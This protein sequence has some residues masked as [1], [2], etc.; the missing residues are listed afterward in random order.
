MTAGESLRS[1][2][3][4]MTHSGFAIENA[5]VQAIDLFYKSIIDRR[6][7]CGFFTNKYNKRLTNI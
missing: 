2:C 1:L 7:A 6:Y 5:F 3:V 4:K